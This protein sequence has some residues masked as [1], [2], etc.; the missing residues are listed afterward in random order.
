MSKLR[1]SLFLGCRSPDT[2]VHSFAQIRLGHVLYQRDQSVQIQQI[3]LS[4]HTTE[5][6]GAQCVQSQPNLFGRLWIMTLLLFF[7]TIHS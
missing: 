1:S 7:S 3:K 2:A 6:K 5:I 4:V